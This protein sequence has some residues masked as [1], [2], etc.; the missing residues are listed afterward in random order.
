MSSL[1]DS[2]VG[3]VLPQV[4]I[5]GALA[6]N[7]SGQLIAAI[8]M[9]RQVLPAIKGDII[10]TRDELKRAHDALCELLDAMENG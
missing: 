3:A 7:L 10:R 4:Q 2:P 8:A 1:L 5:A 9:P 6:T